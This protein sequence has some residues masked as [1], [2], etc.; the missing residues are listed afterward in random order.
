MTDKTKF[1]FGNNDRHFPTIT[2]SSPLMK[3]LYILKKGESQRQLHPPNPP[4]KHGTVGKE[5]GMT[6]RHL[7]KGVC[8]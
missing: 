3:K 2:S 4:E 1:N 8:G 7:Q 5:I 6:S